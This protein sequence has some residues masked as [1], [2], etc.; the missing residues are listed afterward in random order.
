MKTANDYKNVTSSLQS[1]IAMK[2]TESNP[3]AVGK[4]VTE[5]FYTD[6]RSHKIASFDGK[7]IVCED[8]AKYSHWKDGSIRIRREKIKRARITET[9]MSYDDMSF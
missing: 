9:D 2:N 1:M 8:G 6:R 5:F 3:P 7:T 4:Y